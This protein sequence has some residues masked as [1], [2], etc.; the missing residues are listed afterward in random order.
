[1]GLPRSSTALQSRAPILWEDDLP[2]LYEDEED[3][4]GEANL[5]AW[6]ISTLFFCLPACLKKQRPAL[7]VF[8]NMNCYYLPAG[9]SS[10]K[11]GRKPNFASDIMIVHPYEPMPF[12]SVAYTI[13]KHGPAPKV[14]FE[15]LSEETF[16]TRDLKDKLNLYRKLG[17][18]EYIVVDLTGRFLPKKLELRRLQTNGNWRKVKN[19]AGG[20]TSDLGFRVYID[21]TDPLG[22]FVE[23]A[24]TG[25]R[26]IRPHEV[27]EQVEQAN[28]ARR[29]AEEQ[30]NDA[31]R[32]AE[33]Q[34]QQ[35]NERAG[36][37]AEARRLAEERLEALQAE[38]ES[39]RGNS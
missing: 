28:D 14:V 21:A 2:I 30:V 16:E 6:V 12:D 29:R 36:A 22:L 27:E 11:T 8:Q 31:R 34:V 19:V 24:A 18:P 39:L 17:I 13:G 4:M 35:A 23:D 38:M 25:K 1:M 33:E 7:Q 5:H 3:D 32:L 15:V 37:E 10:P 9:R 26:M 20:V